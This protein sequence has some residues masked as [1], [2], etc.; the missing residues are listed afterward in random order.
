MKKKKSEPTV[1]Q[2][3]ILV[4]KKRIFVWCEKIIFRLKGKKHSPPK[5]K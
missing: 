1:F 5:V 3:E 2:Q 4:K